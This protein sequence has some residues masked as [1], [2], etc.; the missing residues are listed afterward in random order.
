MQS[1]LNL[2][3]FSDIVSAQ[4][5]AMQANST[6]ILDFTQG[7]VLLAL[8]EANAGNSIWLQ[9]LASTLLAVTRLS[10]SSGTD[11]DSFIEDFGFFRYQ[12]NAANGNVT[13]SRSTTTLQGVCPIGSIL[14][15]STNPN[16][17]YQVTLNSSLST[18]DPT[19]NA[20]V[21]AV[22]VASITI[23]VVCTIDGTIGNAAI[24][25]IDTIQNPSLCTFDSV[26]NSAAFTTGADAWSDNQTKIEF[27]NYINSLSRANYQ[28]IVYAVSIV[29]N[30]T[31]KVVRYNIVENVNESGSA[32]LGY[33]YVV[34]D[35][36]TGSPVSSQLLTAVTA[37]VENYRGLTIQF[38]VDAAGFIATTIDVSVNLIANPTETN[39]QIINNITTALQAYAASIPFNQPFLYSKISEIVY[40]SDANILSIPSSSAPTLNGLTNDVP[41]NNLDV[42]G[43]PT[44]NVTIL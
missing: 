24:G 28:A 17:Q 36:G 23:P 3:S 2:Q 41:G 29:T 13:L 7:S 8:I 21:A 4:S 6:A 32:Q 27:V 26:T 22:S 37:S 10:T 11:V 20:Y 33:F 34:I 43:I 35:N 15:C 9:A 39:T 42:F 38:N 40:N 44:V 16:L 14:T 19:L 12:G 25:T 1:G 18:Y 30:Q 5:A 31:E